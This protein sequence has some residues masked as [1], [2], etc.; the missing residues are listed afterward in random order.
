MVYNNISS[1][2][3]ISKVLRDLNYQEGEF[4]IS[5]MLEWVGE[6]LRKIGAVK[7][8][9]VK[10]TGKEDLPLLELSNYQ[11]QLPRDLYQFLGVAYS[12]TGSGD[13]IPMRYGTGTYDAR[14]DSTLTTSVGTSY[15]GDN[16]E[17]YLAMDIYDLTYTEA[18]ELLNTN[19]T[20]KDLMSTLLADEK[21]A[22][23]QEQTSTTLD[24]TYVINSSYIKTNIKEGYLML[25]YTCISVDEEGYPLIPDDEMFTEA[26]YWYIVH[27]LLYPKWILGEVRDRVYESAKRSWNFYVKGA[28]A[29]AMMPNADQLE[30]LKNQALKLYPEVGE[31]DNFFSTTGEQQILYSHN[32]YGRHTGRYK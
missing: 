27:K 13:F 25:A 24:Y 3:I 10:V 31:F 9:N 29:A 11:A 7:M 30:S 1:K 12:A 4:R 19:S 20:T 15:A 8:M 17:V 21:G 2:N 5:D 23:I 14:G 26:I 32:Y 18:V 6:A 16:A 28:Y 22:T